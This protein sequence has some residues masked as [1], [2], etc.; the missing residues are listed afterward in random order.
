MH[1]GGMVTEQTEIPGYP[2]SL[3][4]TRHL[5]IRLA[6]TGYTPSVAAG[7]TPNPRSF[8]TSALLRRPPS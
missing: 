4:A 6:Q 3:G 1:P 2:D 7:T 8:L 5:R